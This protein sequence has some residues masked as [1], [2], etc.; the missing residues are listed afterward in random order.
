MN[1]DITARSLRKKFRSTVALDSIDLDVP[2]SSIYALVGPNGAGKTTL[3]KTLMNIHRPTAGRSEVLGV[4]SRK[5][6]GKCFER[7]GYVSENQEFPGWMTVKRF[8]SFLKPFYPTWDS[9]LAEEMLTRFH[10]PSDRKLSKLSRGMRMKAHLISSLA[11]RPR[12]I[13]LDEPF[14]GLDAMV[15]DELIEGLLS[16]AEGTTI[17]ISSHD[18]SEIDS[19]ASNIGYLDEGVLEFSEDI[20]SLRARFREIIVT[21]ETSAG[22]PTGMPETW[23]L[24]ESS[25]ATARFIES[26]YDEQRTGDE[27]RRH[28][29]KLKNVTLNPMTLRSIF[30]ALAK[31]NRERES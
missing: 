30:V 24:P 1:C 5:L 21:L 26:R 13:V 10:L 31:N 23:L 18:L 6:A 20:E 29:P 19:F 17:F 12:L 3:I 28:F 4:D 15:R 2:E 7:I 27:V 25:G 16:L 11:Y 8:L 14:T 9:K 22:M